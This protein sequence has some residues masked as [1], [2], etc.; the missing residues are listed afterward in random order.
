M[1]LNRT[2][3]ALVCAVMV[4]PVTTFGQAERTEADSSNENI[5]VASTKSK[6]EL[7]R[8]LWRAEKDFYSIYNDLNEEKIYDVRCTK[9]APT[10]SVIKVQTC[11][12]KFIDKA[13]REGKISN[14]TSL[15]SD[16]ELSRKISTFREKLD[17][18]LMA[19][20]N[21]RSAATT[22]NQARA[23]LDAKNEAESRN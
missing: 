20:T 14:S 5:V 3:A 22:L 19:D 9:D 7:R 1:K 10:G 23:E 16:P 18:F 4:L 13:L 15:E 2:I 17:A 21:L 8:E 12:P 6:A 11:R